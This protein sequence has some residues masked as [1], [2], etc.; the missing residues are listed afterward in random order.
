M[1]VKVTCVSK[2][3]GDNRDPHEA[4]SKVGW[5]N[6]STGATGTSTRLEIYDFIKKGGE[7]YVVDRFGNRVR[8]GTRENSSGTKFIQTYA[9]Q[10]WTDNLVNQPNC[11]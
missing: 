6:E 1:A 3:S 8:V 10:V 11:P 5:I 7:V 4:I 2:P 9:D